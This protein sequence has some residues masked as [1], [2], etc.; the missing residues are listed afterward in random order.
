MIA[1]LL[2]SPRTSR[3]GFTLIEL[4]V[5]IAI[6]GILIAMLLPGIQ[7]A[8][9]AARRA[10]CVNRLMQLGLALHQYELA[11]EGLP[12]GTVEAK[13]P[14]E[15]K[16]EGY[17]MSWIVQILPYIDERIAFQSVDFDHG[18]YAPENAG[19][20]RLGLNQVICPSFPGQYYV[21]GKPSDKPDVPAQP[22]PSEEPEQWEDRS[23]FD[24][25]E[26]RYDTIVAIDSTYAGCHH[27]VESPIDA[28]NHGMLYLNSHVTT[29]T[30]PD[31][32][33]HT[34]MAGE[35]RDDAELGWMSGTRAT[36]RNTGKS[37]WD[38]YQS[39]SGYPA[40]PAER[41]DENAAQYAGAGE[42]PDD[43]EQWNGM[44]M[45]I[46]FAQGEPPPPPLVVGS[47]GSRH[48][49]VSNFLFADGAV[50]SVSNELDPGTYRQLGH[51]S[52]GKLLMG[53]PTRPELDG[54]R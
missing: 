14:I 16:P 15:S 17:H 27:D 31:G 2:P 22:D 8:R 50:R 5:V 6:I 51:Q 28:D 36:L 53:G 4:L 49:G 47:F 48:P 37:L 29:Y 30:I 44:G 40:P 35:K 42:E 52:D 7:A 45:G 3:A 24:T 12:P 25:W 23:R 43:H 21:Y 10:S 20:R 34:L 33:S 1:K 11:H 18:V 41:Q 32:A 26:E 46:G 39:N 19:V 13:G 9:E 38:V 54:P